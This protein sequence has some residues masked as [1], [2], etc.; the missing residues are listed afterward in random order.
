MLGSISADAA[1]E[2]QLL[3]K[4]T[5]AAP[6]CAGCDG[7]LGQ[8]HQHGAANGPVPLILQTDVR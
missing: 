3:D 2:R 1:T 8:D 6:S 5:T 4:L 7:V